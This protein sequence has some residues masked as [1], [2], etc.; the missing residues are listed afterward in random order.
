MSIYRS[1]RVGK[2]GKQF[3]LLKIRTMREDGGLPTAS[4]NDER[5]T[6]YGKWL[7]KFKLDE[8]PTLLNLLKGDIVIVGP[9]PDT[10]EEIWSLPKY[11]RKTVL[12]LKPG[13]ISPAT[14]WNYKEDE[15]LANKKNPHKYYTQIIK[16]VK[17]KLN[18]WYVSKKSFWFDVRVIL[19]FIFRYLGVKPSKFKIFPPK[20][21]VEYGER[22]C[23][24][25]PCEGIGNGA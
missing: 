23:A 6:K 21:N 19:A 24:K 10:P 5:L 25:R 16:P 11:I 9:R 4:I 7:R 1:L 2:N 8:L 12:S 13:I 22:T 14:L 18:M 3:Y 17:Y 20:C 15:I